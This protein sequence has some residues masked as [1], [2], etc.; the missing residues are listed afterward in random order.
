MLYCALVESH[1]NYGITAWGN[2]SSYLIARL[3]RTQNC[4]ISNITRTG[5]ADLDDYRHLEIFKVSQL[6]LYRVITRNYYQ[7]QF[8]ERRVHEHNTRENRVF[9]E[10]R[11]TNKYGQ[12]VRSRRIPRLLN[13]LPV[14]LRNIGPISR[15]KMGIR[16]WILSGNS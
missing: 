6:H 4:V 11:S 10:D 12:R 13:L 7:G 9:R 5:R 16:R 3:E 1:L 14:E 2:A 15:M 8:R